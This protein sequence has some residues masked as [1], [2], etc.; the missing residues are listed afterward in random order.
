MP[1][2]NETVLI[3]GERYYQHQHFMETPGW[4]DRCANCCNNF[5]DHNN[6]RCPVDEG[7][8]D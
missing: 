7:L 5:M 8:E 4:P 6:G 3:D 2:F 1:D